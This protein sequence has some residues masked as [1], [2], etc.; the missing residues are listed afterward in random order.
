MET[1][2]NFYQDAFKN[3]RDIQNFWE[4]RTSQILDEFVKSQTFVGAMTK[5]MESALD[6]RKIFDTSISRFTEMFDIV[7]KKE[8]DRLNQ[9]AYD[10][11][12]RL[13]KI[14]MGMQ[15]M[16][17]LM[18]RQVELLATIAR[19]QPAAPSSVAS[20]A[21]AAP[22]ATP[23]VATPNHPNNKQGKHEKA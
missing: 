10:G 22:S 21:A 11:N 14:E 1:I 9:Q 15:Q 23:L 8:I 20:V 16:T 13:Q 12:L 7:T 19:I 17:R 2:E 5:S 3:A 6:T 18:E 4:S